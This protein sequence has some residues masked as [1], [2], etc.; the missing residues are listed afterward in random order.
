M[1]NN[2]TPIRAVIFDRDDVLLDFDTNAIM[3]FLQPL[4]SVS[5]SRMS[6][7]WHQWGE[8]IGFPTSVAEETLFWQSFWDF[9]SAKLNLE[10]DVRDKLKQ[11][12]YT[13]VIR[14]FPDARPALELAHQHGLKI[15]V[16]S[17]FSLA[18]IDASLEAANLADLVDIACAATV[19]GVSKPDPAAYLHIINALGV[20]PNQCLFFDN[21]QIH[22]D[23]ATALDMKAYLV[24]RHLNTHDLSQK[25]ICDLSV[26]SQL[27]G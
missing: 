17:N 24:S 19:I 8:Q 9:L 6:Q 5:I 4:L 27:I 1:I 10:N 16:L 2:Q 22:I 11:F 15:G 7:Y 14:P 3:N 13:S 21:K 26:L 25:I 12:D 18:T 23:G 20:S